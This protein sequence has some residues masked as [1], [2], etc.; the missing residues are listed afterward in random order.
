MKPYFEDDWV[1]IFNCDA[2]DIDPPI[3]ANVVM[4]DPPFG[5][6]LD[7]T[8]PAKMRRHSGQNYNFGIDSPEYVEKVVVPVIKRLIGT[9]ERVVVTPGIRC[10]YKYPEPVTIWALYW[11]NGAGRGRWSAF[12]CWSPILCYGKG[13]ARRGSIPDVFR[14][15]ESAERNGHPCP[16]PIGIWRKLLS[17]VTNKGDIIYDPFMGSGTTLRA[18]RD[19]G[20]KSIGVEL[21]EEYCEIAAKRM[22]QMVMEL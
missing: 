13:A 5:V 6:L 17:N 10:M 1:T 2:A 19:I 18:A 9:M 7:S 14:T 20:L 16:K 22:S 3:E 11:P 12:N 21:T 8:R 15:T 4:T